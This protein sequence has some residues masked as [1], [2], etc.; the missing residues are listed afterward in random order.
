MHDGRLGRMWITVDVGQRRDPTVIAVLEEHGQ[1]ALGGKRL[2][3]EVHVRHHERLPLGTRYGAVVARV[4]EVYETCWARDPETVV[5]QSGV[6]RPVVE[7]LRERRVPVIATT[8]TGGEGDSLKHRYRRRD[9]DWTLSRR[10][11]FRSLGALVYAGRLRIP[12]S[13]P[14]A[15]M[16]LDELTDLELRISPSGQERVEVNA[17][18]HHGDTAIAL[19]LCAWRASKA[20]PGKVQTF[21]IDR[22]HDR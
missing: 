20:S 2:P 4:A 6:G 19:G 17:A 22:L 3:S 11:L 1:R 12:R 7:A 21:R 13:L 5:D 10:E 16:I 14:T 15:R 9:E 8:I 18:D